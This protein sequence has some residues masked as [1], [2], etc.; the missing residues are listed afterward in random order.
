MSESKMS[1]RWTMQFVGSQAAVM[2]FFYIDFTRKH[3]DVKPSEHK[4]TEHYAGMPR[5][6]EAESVL[7]PGL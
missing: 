4:F 6:S 3:P 1:V 7:E 5:A 2:H